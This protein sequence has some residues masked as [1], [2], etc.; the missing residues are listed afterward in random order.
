MRDMRTHESFV[1]SGKVR[2]SYKKVKQRNYAW[3]PI[4]VMLVV[5]SA[6]FMAFFTTAP[7]IGTNSYGYRSVENDLGAGNT[8]PDIIP[9]PTAPYFIVAWYG[10]NIHQKMW[11][12]NV[13]R[14]DGNDGS[15]INT[16][17]VTTDL[18]IYSGH[19]S[20]LQPRIALDPDDKAFLVIWYSENKSLVGKILDD[21]G[22]PWFNTFVINDTSV[23]VDYHNFGIAYIGNS[24]FLI[25]WNTGGYDSYFTIVQ[26]TGSGNSGVSVDS[27]KLLS[28]D[29]AHSHVNHPVATNISNDRTMVLWR[30]ST[31]A[32]GKYNITAKIFT[33]N[34]S[35]IVKNDFTVADGRDDSKGYDMPNVAA[36]DNEFFVVYANR[37]SPYDAHAKIYDINGNLITSLDLPTTGSAIKYYGM[38]VAYNGS[39]GFVVTMPD[40]NR[41]IIAIL[42][43]THGNLVWQH[44]IIADG[45]SNEGPRVAVL[46]DSNGNPVY[47]FVWNDA[48]NGIVR[49]SYWQE[50]ELVPEF[51]AAIPML[52][53]LLVLVAIWRRK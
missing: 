23:S 3:A 48:T 2:K 33:S 38:G 18:Y 53:I 41:N 27:S 11:Y 13:T 44:T 8:T 40:N 46:T 32:R 52:A 28:S 21:Q 34:M 22:R 7:H 4:V 5:A 16:N 43:D 36:G 30:N 39:G 45:S 31:G 26:F 12:V 47:Q 17:T 29:T 25:T 1:G 49:T 51:S 35:S 50:S 37:N 42:Y 14:I 19:P 9:V 20:G 10:Y 6:V 15:I 24:K